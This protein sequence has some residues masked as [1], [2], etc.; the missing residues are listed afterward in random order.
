MIVPEFSILHLAN[1]LVGVFGT[2]IGLGVDLFVVPL[3]FYIIVF[4]SYVN[5][6]RQPMTFVSCVVHDATF[7]SHFS[8][9]RRDI[10]LDNVIC[11]GTES[12][13]SECSLTHNTSGITSCAATEHAGVRC[14]RKWYCVYNV[15]IN[16]F[17]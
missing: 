1:A 14:G 5:H 11:Q 13:L 10:V 17:K 15:F 8:T 2:C 4:T 7:R 6:Y 12:L 9:G 16:T 3:P